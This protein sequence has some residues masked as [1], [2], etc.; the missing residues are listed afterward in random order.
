VD[1]NQTINY[2]EGGMYVGEILDGLRH[3]QGTMTYE[4]GDVYTGEFELDRPHGRGGLRI[5]APDS[6]ELERAYEALK[7]AH[8]AGD[9][10]A[11]R[12]LAIYARELQ[13][14]R[15]EQSGGS[16]RGNW[17]RGDL[18]GCS[19]TKNNGPSGF[20]YELTRDDG[21][22]H[23]QIIEYFSETYSV[24]QLE[25]EI[26]YGRRTDFEETRHYEAIKAAYFS[27][28]TPLIA[29]RDY[30]LTLDWENVIVNTTIHNT[31]NQPIRY[32]GFK[33]YYPCEGRT[34]VDVIDE[35]TMPNYIEQPLLPGQSVMTQRIR[36]NNEL[37][38]GL[39]NGTN[40]LLAAVY[41]DY[42][43]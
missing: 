26:Q 19:V 10:S 34:K 27:M 14:E 23:E 41:S 21:I 12:R 33:A 5:S 28:Q 13:A 1:N 20:K 37:K 43:L 4:S 40:C 6:P 39:Q 15:E 9:T 31:S 2:P 30:E 24:R 17:V 7:N 38:S 32:V 22:S 8:D 35:G 25:E 3:G 36:F 18:A 42:P 29:L 16:C 11:A